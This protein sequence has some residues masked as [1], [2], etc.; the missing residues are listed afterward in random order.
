M[1]PF[2][3]INHSH[4]PISKGNEMKNS[5]FAAWRARHFRS[6]RACAV[7][8]GLDPRAVAALEEGHTRN[9]TPCPIPP[10]V[11]WACAAYT[12]NVG[13]Y[14]GGAVTISRI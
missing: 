12:L 9:G 14:D 11:M 4:N 13:E 8:F 2:I 1:W 7:V 10:H 6:R 5:E 3:A